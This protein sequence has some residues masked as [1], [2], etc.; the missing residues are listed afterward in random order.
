MS[1]RGGH[2]SLRHRR[3]MR[4]LIAVCAFGA[5]AAPIAPSGAGAA[6][7]KGEWRAGS[8]TSLYAGPGTGTSTQV[9]VA[10]STRAAAANADIQVTYT[11][12]PANAMAAFQAAV[13]T[14][15]ATISSNVVIR[16]QASWTNLGST[17]ILGSAGPTTIHRNFSGGTTNRWYPAALA[18]KIAGQDLN[19]GTADIVAQFNSQ[20]PNWYFG[21]SG[22][23]PANQYDLQSVVL[24]EIGHGLG[25]FTSFTQSGSQ[26]VW[27]NGGFPYIQDNYVVNGSNTLLITFTSGSAALKTQA[28][29]N[30]VFWNGPKGKAANGGSNPKLYAPNPWRQ[31]SSLS[32]LDEATYP[33]GN[34]NS[35]MTP[36][37]GQGERIVAPGPIT[38]GLLQDS[39]WTSPK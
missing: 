2:R 21:T 9:G 24:H 26:I 23:T 19:G 6:P 27:G 11:N 30:N 10:P 37:I 36:S 7:A 15:E 18:N 20:F 28:T 35:L 33:P 32:H 8:L 38:V 16:I 14:W 4:F 34:V 17:G 25:L 29:S 3:S 1:F 39:G 31:G 12:F 22:P 13:N 5:L